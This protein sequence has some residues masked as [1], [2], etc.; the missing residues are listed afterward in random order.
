M[1]KQFPEIICIC[2]TWLTPDFSDCLFPHHDKYQIFRKDRTLSRGGGV[3]IMVRND[4]NC[5]LI[6]HDCL[7]NV[8]ALCVR[9][10]CNNTEFYVTNIYR[11][12]VAEISVLKQY[13]ELFR[14]LTDTKLPV[15]I[16]G[17]F[18]LP[19]INWEIPNAPSTF[20]QNQFLDTFLSYGLIQKVT[21]PTVNWAS[22]CP[23]FVGKILNVF[24]FFFR[25]S[26]NIRHAVL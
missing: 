24:L 1:A 22:K 21:T 8:E 3:V 18:N 11:R 26:V 7:A 15:V 14:L 19:G 12:N 9:V 5:H 6:E 2:E 17:D 13:E 16:V 4:L 25:F 20:C 23:V 10:K